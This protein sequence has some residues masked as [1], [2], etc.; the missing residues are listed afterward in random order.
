QRLQEGLRG[1]GMDQRDVVVVAE[2]PDD[3]LALVLAQQSVVDEHALQLVADR[4]VQQHGHDTRVDA[5]T[6]ATDHLALADLGADLGDGAPAWR[7]RAWASPRGATARRNSRGSRR[8]WR[9]RA[10]SRSWRRRR[11]RPAA[12]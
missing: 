4:L 7:R 10:R 2:Q 5:A 9:R 3:L 6:E 8:R 1:V 11:S 12:W